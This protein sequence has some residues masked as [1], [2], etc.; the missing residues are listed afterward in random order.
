MQ[1][2]QLLPHRF[3]SELELRRQ[4]RDRGHAALLQ[5]DQNRAPAF[6]NLVDGDDGVSPFV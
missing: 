2:Q 6:R 5:R 4:V 1:L 3:T